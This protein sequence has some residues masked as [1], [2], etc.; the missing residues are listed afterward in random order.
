MVNKYILKS[1]NGKNEKL[2]E[3]EEIDK[4]CAYSEQLLTFH[5]F[6]PVYGNLNILPLE[7]L[8]LMNLLD[9]LFS[10]SDLS[11]SLSS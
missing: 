9:S 3:K 2:L 5:F 4:I 6:M 8:N 7:F 10:S 11:L 1:V